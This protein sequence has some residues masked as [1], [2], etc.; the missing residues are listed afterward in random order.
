MNVRPTATHQNSHAPRQSG[1]G[2][3][4]LHVHEVPP[5]SDDLTDHD[6]RTDQVRHLKEGQLLYLR[7]DDHAQGTADDTAVNGKAARAN[8]KNLPKMILKIQ[9]PKNF[10]NLSFLGAFT[11]LKTAFSESYMS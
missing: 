7:H 3:K 6:R 10:P 9:V 1:F 4:G 5:P 2:A 8:I 11:P